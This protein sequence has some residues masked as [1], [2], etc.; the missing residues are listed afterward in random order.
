MVAEARAGAPVEPVQPLVQR[1]VEFP[2]IAARGEM[3]ARVIIVR[4]EII[5]DGGPPPDNRSV[6]YFRVSRKF[7]DEGWMVL[8]ASDSYSYFREL[9]R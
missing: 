6:R 9:L 1:N 3:G 4:A 8:G 5:V 2:S 7:T